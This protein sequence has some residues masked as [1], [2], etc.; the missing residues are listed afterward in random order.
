MPG[1][2]LPNVVQ[3]G[4]LHRTSYLYYMVPIMPGVYLV[5]AELFRRLPRAA[6]VGWAA[7]L[8]YGFQQLYPFRTW[9]G[10]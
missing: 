5:V 3:S 4:A 1:T 7:A 8:G 6:L 9:T 10:G 2:F